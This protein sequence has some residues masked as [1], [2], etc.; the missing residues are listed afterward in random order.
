MKEQFPDILRNAVSNILAESHTCIPGVIESYSNKTAN[1]KPSINRIIDGQELEMPIITNVPVMFPGTNN[2]IFSFPLT[3]GDGCL[4]LF[5]ERSMELY[6][7]SATLPIGPGDSRKYSLT[8]AICIPG[9]FPTGQGKQPSNLHIEIKSDSKNIEING[10]E[11]NLN[12]GNVGVAR[13]NDTTQLSLNGIDIQAL[14]A[15]LLTTL[16]FTPTGSPPIPA[17]IPVIFTGG[18]ITSASPTVKAG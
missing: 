7:N 11:I 2:F 6:L 16:A 3:K 8:D 4:L 1:V 15:A 12:S 9:L 18:Q 5:S 17:T 13:L 14:A 10:V